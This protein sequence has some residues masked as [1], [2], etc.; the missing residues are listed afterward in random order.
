MS[1]CY[2]YWIHLPNHKIH[3]GY[4]GITKNIDKRWKYHKSGYG[5]CTHLINAINK[6]G[7]TLVWEVI[8]EGSKEDCYLLEQSLRPN[9]NIGWNIRPGGCDIVDLTDEHKTN[10]KNAHLGK[11]LS[12]ET[13]R[14][15]SE[16]HKGKK[17]SE[18][19]KFNM[20]KPK[21]AE[22]KKKLSLAKQGQTGTKANSAKLVDVYEYKTDI[23]VAEQVCLAEWGQKNNFGNISNLR[24]TKNAD[25][26]KPSSRTNRHQSKGYYIKSLVSTGK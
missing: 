11:K 18:Q 9:A 25:R 4:I 16:S 21:T 19:A 2:V 26:T 15:I 1:E 14:K 13:K 6:Y 24:S 22:H 17:M 20:K 3:E 5:K 12:E 10:I 23:L 7:D 8:R